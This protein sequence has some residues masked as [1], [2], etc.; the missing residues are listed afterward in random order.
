MPAA[1]RS[2]RHVHWRAATRF[3]GRHQRQSGRPPSAK[4]NTAATTTTITGCQ[5]QCRQQCQ[6]GRQNAIGSA[7]ATA[8]SGR[9]R[10]RPNA[11]CWRCW[12]LFATSAAA[13]A[14]LWCDSLPHST[15]R[16]FMR[17]Q[18]NSRRIYRLAAVQHGLCLAGLDDSAKGD[19]A[20]PTLAADPTPAPQTSGSDGNPR[21][22]IGFG[23]IRELVCATESLH[24][25]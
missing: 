23:G 6:A 3:S 9:K 4:S 11:E 24:P 25:A 12:Y 18:S 16:S 1:T 7:I 13:A 17:M 14:A 2:Q 8:A 19:A 21:Q 15:H 5:Q 20:M 22:T 10:H